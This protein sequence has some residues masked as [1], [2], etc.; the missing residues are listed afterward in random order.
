MVTVKSCT[1]LL[2][3]THGSIYRFKDFKSIPL[4]KNNLININY[5]I[6]KEVFG[7][8]LKEKNIDEF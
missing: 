2:L 4:L 3:F 1:C 6:G 8:D 5:F 7:D